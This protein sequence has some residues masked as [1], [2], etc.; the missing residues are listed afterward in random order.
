MPK[1]LIDRDLVIRA[2]NP[3]FL[4]ATGHAQDTLLHREVFDAFPDNPAHPDAN[5]VARNVWLAEV[6]AALIYQLGTAN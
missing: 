6:A 4:R 1:V 2:A 5:G 3:A